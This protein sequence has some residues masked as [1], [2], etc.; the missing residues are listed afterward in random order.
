MPTAKSQPVLSAS[1]AR[2]ARRRADWK[3]VV[4]ENFAEAEAET[5]AYWRAATPAERFNALEKLREPFYGKDQIGGRLQRFLEV[6]P[7]E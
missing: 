4:A 1:Q 3:I 6:V 7:A 5:R 2:T